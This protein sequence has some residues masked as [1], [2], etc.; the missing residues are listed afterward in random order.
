MIPLHPT[1]RHLTSPHLTPPHLTPH[2]IPSHPQVREVLLEIGSGLKSWA[3]EEDIQSAPTLADVARW[4]DGS[5][6]GLEAQ[7]PEPLRQAVQ[8]RGGGE[9]ASEG[10]DVDLGFQQEVASRAAQREAGEERAR[11]RSFVEGVSRERRTF[12]AAA[13]AAK[14]SAVGMDRGGRGGGTEEEEGGGEVETEDREWWM[15]QTAI[16]VSGGARVATSLGTKAHP[17]MD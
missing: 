12:G 13:V 9:G 7:I 1:S 10:A 8:G 15:K 11:V 16:W 4:G 14:Y 3:T 5:R 2:L 6:E 17:Y